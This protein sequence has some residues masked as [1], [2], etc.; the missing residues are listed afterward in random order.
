MTIKGQPYLKIHSHR[1]VVQDF[2]IGNFP[3]AVEEK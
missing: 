3:E 1:T 2:G